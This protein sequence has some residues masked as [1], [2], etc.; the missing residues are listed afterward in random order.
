[1]TKMAPAEMEAFSQKLEDFT[2]HL[3]DNERTLFKQMFLIDRNRLSDK[4]LD[5]V[6]GGAL[7]ARFDGITFQHVAPR[8]NANFFK[9]MCW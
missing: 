4:A 9:L 3:S 7:N 1:M 2:S 8:L 5:Q 6:T